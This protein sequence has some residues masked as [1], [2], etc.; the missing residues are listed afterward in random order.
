MNRLRI[1]V[2][3]ALLGV[4]CFVGELCAQQQTAWPMGNP[5]NPPAQPGVAA[6]VPSLPPLNIAKIRLQEVNLDP[7]PRETTA[8]VPTVV[9]PEKPQNRP[10]SY[11]EVIVPPNYTDT[12]SQSDRWHSTSD[13]ATVLL[14][15]GQTQGAQQD[16]GWNAGNQYTPN[17]QHVH[18]YGA[19]ERSQE[20]LGARQLSPELSNRQLQFNSSLPNGASAVAPTIPRIAGNRAKSVSWGYPQDQDD[21]FGQLPPEGISGAPSTPTPQTPP[22]LPAP[23]TP[24]PQTPPTPPMA[25]VPPTVPKIPTPQDP[26]DPFQQLPGNTNEPTPRP[27]PRPRPRPQQPP[28]SETGRQDTEPRPLPNGELTPPTQLPIPPIERTPVPTNPNQGNQDNGNGGQDN[29]NNGQDSNEQ[30]LIVYPDSNIPGRQSYP[31]PTSRHEPELEPGQATAIDTSQIIYGDSRHE[32]Q[33]PG[34]NSGSVLEQYNPN[35]ASHSPLDNYAPPTAGPQIAPVNYESEC[36]EPC[37][38]RPQLAI[39]L[40]PAEPSFEPAFYLSLFGGLNHIDDLFG[41]SSIDGGTSASFSPDDGGGFGFA[42]GQY[43]GYNL[44]TEFEYSFRTNDVDQIS[45]AEN[46][47][48]ALTFTDFGLSGELA[49]H[50]GMGNI[51]WQ[52]RGFKSRWVRPYVGAGAGFVFLDANFDRFGQDILANGNDGDSTFAYQLFGGINVQL[53]RQMDVFLEYR[54]F[55]ADSL[56][57]ETGFANV[58][59]DVGSVLEDFDYEADNVFFGIRFKF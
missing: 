41:N 39:G 2:L 23:L 31:G 38:W 11:E 28:V 1:R 18:P 43:Q 16:A 44:R 30:E 45:L 27:R 48:N 56:R 46:V 33:S 6:S 21:P 5:A 25:P 9:A 10:V 12:N 7:P 20:Q 54:H 24:P 8:V 4:T 52:F 35:V 57:L 51:I 15:R 34:Q 40:D 17:I 53:N 49:A 36:C 42:L 3:F 19:P 58:N 32:T 26:Q 47:G 14:A 55:A 22:T 50:S 13:P 59:G 29:G 37:G